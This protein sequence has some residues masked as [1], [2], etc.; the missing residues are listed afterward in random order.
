MK[1]TTYKLSVQVMHNK[2]LIYSKINDVI[3]KHNKNLF[4]KSIKYRH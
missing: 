2:Y 1:Q 4:N 3:N